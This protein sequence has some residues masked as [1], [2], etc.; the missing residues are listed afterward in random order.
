VYADPFANDS[1]RNR[2]LYARE[3]VETALGAGGV[4]QG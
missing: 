4:V 2:A 3:V 1:T